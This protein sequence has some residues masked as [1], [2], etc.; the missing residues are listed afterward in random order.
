MLGRMIPHNHGERCPSNVLSVGVTYQPIQ[1]VKSAVVQN[2]AFKSAHA[3]SCRL[4]KGQIRN[5]ERHD[6]KTLHDVWEL[7]ASRIQHDRP[8]WCFMY[9]VPH[10]FT[11]LGGW[12]KWRQGVIGVDADEIEWLDSA[13]W[14][15][16]KANKRGLI[17]D[18]DPPVVFDLWHQAGGRVIFCD[19]MNYWNSSIDDN[20]NAGTQAEIVHDSI[21]GLIG[22]HKTQKLGNWALTAAGLGW[23]AWRHKFMQQ[24]VFP[25]GIDDIDALER[26]SY[27]GGWQELFY[28]VKVRR[29]LA[30]VDVNGLYPYVMRNMPLPYEMRGCSL[31]NNDGDSPVEQDPLSC[32]ATVDIASEHEH[33]PLRRGKTHVDFATGH[34]RTTLAGP[35]L[36][37][38][39]V[40]GNVVNIHEWSQYWIAPLFTEFVDYF[41]GQKV[42]AAVTG[43]TDKLR[44]CKAALVGL[45]GRFARKTPL[46]K[47]VADLAAL[48]VAAHNL[49]KH[50]FASWLELIHEISGQTLHI[51]GSAV[52]KA[53]SI[54]LIGRHWQEK[55]ETESHQNAFPAIASFV[56]AYGREYM[57]Q[58]AFM[59]GTRNVYRVATDSLVVNATGFE[60]LHQRGKLHDTELGKLKVENAGSGGDFF[61]MHF[62]RLGE[63]WTRGG[64]SAE[65]AEQPDGTILHFE[66]EGL[67]ALIESKNSTI[68]RRRAVAK[69]MADG[70]NA[71][72][73]QVGVWLD[74]KHIPKHEESNNGEGIDHPKCDGTQTEN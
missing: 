35:E 14:M 4:E 69:S 30:Q 9:R 56:T 61:G 57:R 2:M 19:Y 15:I 32:I 6:I 68:F 52:E 5:A 18:N 13:A 23:N 45:Y 16:P 31:W 11:V 42:S 70:Y 17:V 73:G 66:A 29:S 60:A 36:Q 48:P 27:F 46:W 20:G 74:R 10:A 71:G 12:Q 67:D 72:N 37:R 7:I 38:A 44:L 59:A 54:R 26:K 40:L 24:P 33:Y 51:C 21:T 62:F 3:I 47:S 65:F 28:R 1:S 55:D 34:F 50:E 43:D 49:S 25:H 22:E 8:L 39:I 64:I 41:H 63:K 58:L 53:R